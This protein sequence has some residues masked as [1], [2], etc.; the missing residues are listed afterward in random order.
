[1][2]RKLRQVLRQRRYSYDREQD[3][4]HVTLEQLDSVFR[5]IWEEHLPDEEYPG[6]E[7]ITPPV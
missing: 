7:V 3:A 6:A 5:Q 2:D 1:M 4:W